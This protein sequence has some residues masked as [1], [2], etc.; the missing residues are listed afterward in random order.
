MTQPLG[1]DDFFALEAGEYLDRLSHL[2]ADPGP[3]SADELVRFTRAL[4]G[5]ALMANQQAIARAA[6]GLEHLVRGFRDGRRAWDGEMAALFREATDVL[7]TLV[8]RAKMWTPDDGARA[9]RLALH[10]ERSAGGAPRPVTAPSPSR[11]ETGVRAFLAREAAAL[12]SV[13]DQASRLLHAGSVSAD[14]M[15]GVLRRMQP[16]R[17]LAALSD[18]SPLPDLLE[19]IER[20]VT[21]VGRLELPAADGARRLDAAA[22]GL[23]RAARDIADRGRPDPDA[24]EFRQFAEALVAPPSQEIA[25]V[26][27]DFLFFAGEDGIVQR[28]TAPRSIPAAALGSAAVVSQGE[29]LCQAADEVASARSAPQR[30]LRLHVLAGDLRTLGAGLPPALEAAV[31][32][33]AAAA[34]EAIARGAAGAQ[35]TEYAE[36]IREAGSRLRAFTEVTQPGTLTS[37]F[38]QLM[39]TME[40]LGAEHHAPPMS[41]GVPAT[42]PSMVDDESDVVPIESLL[43]DEPEAVPIE[44]LAPDAPATTM[45]AKAPTAIPAPSPVAPV[46]ERGLVIPIDRGRGPA[47]PAPVAESPDR[48]GWDLTASYLSYEALLAGPAAPAAAP[49]PPRPVPEPVPAPDRAVAAAP[50]PPPPP[51]PRLAVE[52]ELPVVDIGTLL[53]RG[54][55]ALERADQVQRAIRSAVSMAQPMSTIQPMV[56]ELLDLVELAIAD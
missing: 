39:G 4:R 48:D 23:S 32:A 27:I 31:H 53:Y 6:G 50:A 9:E 55:A 21:A 24:E 1:I 14:A 46:A 37:V 15:Q 43:Y 22:A 29:H 30:D 19:G 35:P 18:Y 13:L 8:E 2:A 20:T 3:P 54:R 17:G 12:G 33:F 44:S 11:H 34:R 56:D 52:P 7:R 45:T 47:R 5:S 49:A 38:Q 10:L 42:V 25:I 41:A 51:P 40:R 36:L 16:L 28:G 26:P